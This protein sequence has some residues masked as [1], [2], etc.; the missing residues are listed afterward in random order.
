MAYETINAW[1]FDVT[2]SWQDSK[3]IPGTDSNPEPFQLSNY[4]PAFS[5]INLQVSKGLF[6]RLE[7]YAGAENLFDFRQDDP[8]IASDDPFGPYFD[9]SLIWGPVFG[10]KL[11]AGLRFRIN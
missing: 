8:I 10:R 9:S 4:S 5:L 1:A 6:E 7:V 2:W 3:R 11:Y